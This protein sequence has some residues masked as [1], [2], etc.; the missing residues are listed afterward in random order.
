[1]IPEGLR[2][3]QVVPDAVDPNAVTP[4]IPPP[5]SSAW[6]WSMRMVFGHACTARTAALTEKQ[7]PWAVA[8]GVESCV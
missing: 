2:L 8:A 7:L 1:M 3:A 5:R 6:V 4:Y